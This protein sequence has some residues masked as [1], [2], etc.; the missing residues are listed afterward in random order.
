MS[1]VFSQAN[2]LIKGS[3]DTEF[4][5]KRIDS[6]TAAAD[7]KSGK[8]MMYEAFLVTM[9]NYVSVSVEYKAFVQ[10]RLSYIFGANLSGVDLTEEDNVLADSP[11]LFVL[12]GLI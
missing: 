5:G 8:R 9:T 12:I 2:D 11:K 10:N 1:I 3:M 6:Q 4:A 7:A